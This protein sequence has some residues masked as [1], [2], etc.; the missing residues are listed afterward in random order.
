MA[1]PALLQTRAKTVFS[2]V[3]IAVATFTPEKLFAA[4]LLQGGAIEKCR[5]SIHYL[6]KN[7]LP[8]A[9]LKLARISQV[10]SANSSAAIPTANS[11]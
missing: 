1:M 5:G 10:I 8:G 4:S 3:S 9:N 6:T 11:T 7:F 2:D